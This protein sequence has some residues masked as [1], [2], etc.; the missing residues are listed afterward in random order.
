MSLNPYQA[1]ETT[2]GINR[3]AAKIAIGG[4]IVITLAISLK[5]YLADDA[6][7]FWQM[8]IALVALILLMMLLSE[9]P[10]VVAR[11]T[12]S[13]FCFM[14]VV[15][16][17]AG[18]AQVITNNSVPHLTQSHCIF[19]MG[20]SPGC[21]ASPANASAQAQTREN[22][23]PSAADTAPEPAPPAASAQVLPPPGQPTR[24]VELGAGASREFIPPAAAEVFLLYAGLDRDQTEPLAQTLRAAGWNVQS[25]DRGGDRVDAAQGLNEVR[26]FNAADLD[27]ARH[28]AQL[29]AD[30]RPD[31]A[32]MALQDLSETRHGR[33]AG[34]QFE[35]WISR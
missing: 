35:V 26:F 9:L 7:T 1:I 29:V 19:S 10:R 28:L 23:Q 12:V 21:G 15:W 11:I 13:I 24:G 32:G 3:T 2:L 33:P 4:W 25:A 34:Q 5:Q 22:V 17:T 27:A 14:F 31:P 20:Y 8:L 30:S 16:A 18:L 6:V